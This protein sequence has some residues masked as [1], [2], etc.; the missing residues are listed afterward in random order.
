MEGPTGKPYRMLMESLL[1][2]ERVLHFG[3]SSSIE[4]FEPQ[5]VTLEAKALAADG[6]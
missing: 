6:R 1:V 3:C 4:A 5:K 2:G